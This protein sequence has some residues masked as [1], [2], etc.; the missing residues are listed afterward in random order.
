MEND[1]KDAGGS[2]CLMIVDFFSVFHAQFTVVTETFK[3][4]ERWVSQNMEID[5]P[6][7]FL[8]IFSFY[9][10]IQTRVRSKREFWWKFFAIA[11]ERETRKQKLFTF[12]GKICV[13]DTAEK[14]ITETARIR[15]K[16]RIMKFQHN[17]NIF[18]SFH[19]IRSS[20]FFF[21]F[22]LSL[23]PMHML[24][25]VSILFFLS[26]TIWKCFL[27]CSYNV[28]I[29]AAR[30]KHITSSV[31]SFDLCAFCFVCAMFLPLHWCIQPKRLCEH[32]F[33]INWTISENKRSK[34]TIRRRNTQ[35]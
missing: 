33:L 15:A 19:S 11:V 14:S 20:S 24:N 25:K 13:V 32:A 34:I 28:V 16:M 17:E 1:T 22:Y 31:D 9:V 18:C 10:F 23:L 30:Y 7:F 12:G 27:L 6:F 29:N 4:N 3:K 2:E 35:V 8:F 21:A 26:T 5:K